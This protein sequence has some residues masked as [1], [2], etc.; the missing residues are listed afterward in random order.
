MTP[1]L[2][3]SAWYPHARP[4]AWLRGTSFVLGTVIPLAA[5]ATPLI[6]ALPSAMTLL[7][8]DWLGL[9]MI[10]VVVAFPLGLWLIVGVS[11]CFYDDRDAARIVAVLSGVCLG[12]L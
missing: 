6:M 4:P 12:L 8:H 9:A 10:A 11:A 5:A 2:F 1:S 3:D 7:A